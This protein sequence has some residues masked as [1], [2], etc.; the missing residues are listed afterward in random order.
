[1]KFIKFSLN[2]LI[3]GRKPSTYKNKKIKL[4]I[5]DNYTIEIVFERKDLQ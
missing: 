1:M 3:Q 4:V 5:I 2:S